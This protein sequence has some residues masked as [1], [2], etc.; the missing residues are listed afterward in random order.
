MGIRL[1]AGTRTLAS[2]A[3]AALLAGG[4]AAC[5][6]ETGGSAASPVKT[7]TATAP[8]S[9]DTGN[10]AAASQNNGNSAP[11]SQNNG[12][13]AGSS[14]STTE[15]L[16][17]YR[18]ATVVSE[19]STTTVLKSPDSV[20]KVGA[21]Y[22]SALANGGWDTTSASMGPFHASFTAHRAHEGVSISVYFS[23]GGAGISVSRYPV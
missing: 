18:P 8:A 9:R 1:A 22:K 5:S 17:D 12:S 6:V 20:A 13:P 7:V 14:A 15:K 3:A 4:L 23:L 10:A 16:P 2:V 11:A 19:S 21:F